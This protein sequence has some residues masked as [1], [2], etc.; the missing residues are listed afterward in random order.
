MSKKRNKEEIKNILKKS[1]V[2]GSVAGVAA[3]AG[4][5]L[6][7][8]TSASH[9]G[10]NN[11]SVSTTLPGINNPGDAVFA[12]LNK[13]SGF[14][15]PTGKL[16]ETLI[17]SNSTL[18]VA[19]GA[20]DMIKVGDKVFAYTYFSTDTN[21]N[22]S[23]Y[24]FDSPFVSQ[25]SNHN[26]YAV[27]PWHTYPSNVDPLATSSSQSLF[28]EEKALTIEGF[29]AYL[30]GSGDWIDRAKNIVIKNA[31]YDNTNSSGEVFK[32]LYWS[33]QDNELLAMR[34]S[35][36]DRGAAAYPGA[37]GDNT[38]Y[39]WNT[40][41]DQTAVTPTERDAWFKPSS[42]GGDNDYAAVVPARFLKGYKDVSNEFV[43]V[44]SSA[45]IEPSGNNSVNS[46]WNIGYRTV[47]EIVGVDRLDPNWAP[48]LNSGTISQS[49]NEGYLN[50][51]ISLGVDKFEYRGMT[52]RNNSRLDATNSAGNGIDYNSTTKKLVASVSMVDFASI[53]GWN[54]N[55]RFDIQNWD[56]DS[57]SFYNGVNTEYVQDGTVTIGSKTIPNYV[58]KADYIFDHYNLE[59]QTHTFGNPT[60]AN[61][62]NR[63]TWLTNFA[64]PSVP[65][66]SIEFVSM[67]EASGNGKTA[68]VE[69]KYNYGGTRSETKTLTVN[70]TNSL[71][72]MHVT[73][74]DTALDA[75]ETALRNHL[76]AKPC[77]C[78]S[79]S[80][81]I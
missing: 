38:Y 46:S 50:E 7:Q 20:N 9:N 40:D 57:H 48:K 49:V 74:R 31:K 17:T 42:Q 53:S 2:A 65:G 68:T 33:A 6:L 80:W 24:H 70:Y 14:S 26:F 29:N 41:I 54:G 73:A 11:N 15:L 60:L 72:D 67:S 47:F 77:C 45:K 19:D 23:A 30:Q 18:T 34:N 32:Y 5:M 59:G 75:A 12:S 4:A 56:D 27:G 25:L 78:S 1:A 36:A 81:C 66:L 37:Q 44:I 52:K 28:A 79:F 61:E 35:T 8:N 64:D 71:E 63:G 76:G 39:D 58:T 43:S 10:N 62:T 22:Q 21:K 69:F 3:I 55:D 16:S 51:E 13:P